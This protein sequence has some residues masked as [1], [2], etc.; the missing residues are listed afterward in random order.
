[1][2]PPFHVIDYAGSDKVA[3]FHFRHL[4][5]TR[6]RLFSTS[7]TA[8]TKIMEKLSR[9]LE[10][11]FKEASESQMCFVDCLCSFNTWYCPDAKTFSFKKIFIQIY[12]KNCLG[13]KDF[14]G[15]ISN[16][17]R[18]HIWCIYAAAAAGLKCILHLFFLDW[19][20]FH[21]EFCHLLM[22]EKIFSNCCS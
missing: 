14:A 16:I 21:L 11:Q 8:T 2:P 5:Y 19:G 6:L 4:H 22:S 15:T 17:S 7:T 3:H 1:M 20:Y 18:H 12:L 13:F 9:I 10:P